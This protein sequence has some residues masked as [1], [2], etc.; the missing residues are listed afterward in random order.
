MS[1]Q[2]SPTELA[3][4][5][6]TLLTDP[7]SLGE[8]DTDGKFSAFMTD[9]AS[10]VCDHCGGEVRHAAQY[11]DDTWYVGIHGN[12]SLPADGGVWKDFDTEGELFPAP[13]DSQ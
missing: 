5:V 6:T 7:A 4:L 12:D 10:A 11:T 9:I 3:K 8:L 2:I 1:K 13:D